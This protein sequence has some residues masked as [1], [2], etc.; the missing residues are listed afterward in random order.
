M[1]VVPCLFENLFNPNFEVYE[2]LDS[3]AIAVQ[4][5]AS[6]LSCRDNQ[7]VEK[8]HQIAF[9]NGL[10]NSIYGSKE[11]L[12]MMS[13]DDIKNYFK[14]NVT[15]DRIAVVATGVAHEDLKTVV[16]N[17]LSKLSIPAS[18]GTTGISLFLFRFSK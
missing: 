14:K 9:R 17:V 18:N 6:A 7:I 15:A 12:S 1:D 3:S 16:S 5:T 13:R 11:F 10:G 8:L 4:Q 2:F